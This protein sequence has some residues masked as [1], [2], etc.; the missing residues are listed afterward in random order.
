MNY[1]NLEKRILPLPKPIRTSLIEEFL[2]DNVLVSVKDMDVNISTEEGEGVAPMM[3]QGILVD[4]DSR[5]ILLSDNTETSFSLINIDSVVKIDTIDQDME[6][7]LDP[8]KP[9]QSE[10]N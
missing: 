10:M 9:K 5:F 7:L 3:L 8:N 4:Y 2:G 1:V 6:Q